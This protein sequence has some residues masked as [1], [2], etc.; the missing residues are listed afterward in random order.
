[1]ARLADGSIPDV[2]SS[3]IT[4]WTRG[5]VCTRVE[6]RRGAEKGGGLKDSGLYFGVPDEGDADGEF[7]LHPARQGF[8]AGI[9]LVFQV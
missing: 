2:G 1:M 6:M 3:N 5:K 7:P 8:R 9:P 4:T